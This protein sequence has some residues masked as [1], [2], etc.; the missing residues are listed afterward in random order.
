MKE[1]LIIVS[2]NKSKIKASINNA[3]IFK[4]STRD[5]K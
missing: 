2:R 3:K 1:E 4:R 5:I